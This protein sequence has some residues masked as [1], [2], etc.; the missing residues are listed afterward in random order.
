MTIGIIGTGSVGKTLGTRWAALGHQVIFGSRHPESPENQQL[1]TKNNVGVTDST[2]A[3][4]GSDIVVL[5]V[6]WTS[7][8][9]VLREPEVLKG[10]ILVDCMNPLA[11]G[12]TFDTSHGFESGAAFVQHLAPGA[13]VVKAF[14]TTGAANMANPEIRGIRLAMFICG[15]DEDAKNTVAGLAR[16]LGFD[17]IDN[18]GLTQ[19][20]HLESLAYIWITQAYR[21]NWGPDF[22]LAV[23]NR[24]D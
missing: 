6:P 16:E 23:L 15:D 22:G 11:Q 17:A 7:V 10:K 14:N 24:N 18:G 8:Q 3:I 1:A 13:R 21:Q 4:A 20:G 5:A 9:S 19:A 2:S 12:L